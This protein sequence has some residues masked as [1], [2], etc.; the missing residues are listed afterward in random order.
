MNLRE[1]ASACL[2]EG[3]TLLSLS[4]SGEDHL[5]LAAFFPPPQW[6]LLTAD[7]LPPA[8]SSFQQDEIAVIVCERDLPQASWV[9][10]LNQVQRWANPPSLIVT[11]RLADEYLWAEALNLGAW[12]VLAKPFARAEVVRSVESA[13]GHRRHWRPARA[14]SAANSDPAQ[15]RGRSPYTWRAG[16]STASF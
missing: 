3:M 11:S 16:G 6:T 7:R 14:D 9:D 13:W 8:V 2:R 10:V 4:P 5:A 12:D 1:G 15:V